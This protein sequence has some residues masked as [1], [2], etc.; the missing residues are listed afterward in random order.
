MVYW[1]LSRDIGIDLLPFLQSEWHGR[2]VATKEDRKRGER[3]SLV[4]IG[5]PLFS[6]RVY[7]LASSQQCSWK[8]TENAL[9]M[10]LCSY[11]CRR[12][13]SRVIYRGTSCLVS[14]RSS[15]N[16]AASSPPCSSYSL[17]RSAVSRSREMSFRS[18][19]RLI[20]VYFRFAHASRKIQTFHVEKHA[21]KKNTLSFLFLNSHIKSQRCI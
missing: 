16:L 11:G 3:R 5:G 19:A 7:N 12:R 14:L 10:P 15:L 20:A 4:A 21:I 6:M 18:A 9:F 13:T 1:Q 2:L 8:E 17:D